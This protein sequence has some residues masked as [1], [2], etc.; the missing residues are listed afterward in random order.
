MKLFE[1]IS[2][3]P[4]IPDEFIESLELIESR[5]N[6]NPLQIPDTYASRLVDPKLHEWCQSFFSYP[7]VTRWQVQKKDLPIHV[8]VGIKG[9][10]YI[11]YVD[12]GGK[13]VET[14]F[15]DNVG[16]TANLID[17]YTAKLYTWCTFK[18]DKPHSTSGCHSPRLSVTIKKNSRL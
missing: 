2:W 7:I 17:R 15:W 10:K 18:I 1:E 9:I 5:E 6:V 16:P 8:D 13:N 14:L 11:Y 12:L 3:L 4:K